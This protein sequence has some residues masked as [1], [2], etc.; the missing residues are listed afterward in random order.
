MQNASLSAVKYWVGE[1]LRRRAASSEFRDNVEVD[2]MAHDLGM[3]AW[4]LR[5]LVSQGP[6]AAQLLGAR[7]A[8]LGLDESDLVEAGPETT[9]DLQ[10]SCSLCKDHHRCRNDLESHDDSDDWLRYC[11]NALT[12]QALR[13]MRSRL[14]A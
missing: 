1:Y 14:S 6:A 7:M 2:R 8:E 4:E 13:A 12:L 9:R 11:P 10:R 3:S 5:A